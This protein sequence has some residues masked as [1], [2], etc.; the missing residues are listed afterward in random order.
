M[1]IER[2]GLTNRWGQPLAFAMRRF[3]FMKQFSVFATPRRR[4]RWLSCVSLANSKMESPQKIMLAIAWFRPE[5]WEQLREVAVD[6]D[7]LERTHGEWEKVARQTIKD[8]AKQGFCRVE[9]TWMYSTY[10][11]GVRI[12]SGRSMLRRE[13]LTRQNAFDMAPNSPNQSLARFQVCLKAPTV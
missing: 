11:F 7:I 10:R 4:Q 1:I 13:P 9:S 5:Q 8:L 6:A 12:I 2:T 3:N